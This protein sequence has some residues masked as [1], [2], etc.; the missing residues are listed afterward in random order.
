MSKKAIGFILLLPAV[1][2]SLAAM[3]AT[4]RTIMKVADV[5]ASEA[6]GY[7]RGYALGSI[8]GYAFLIVVSIYLWKWVIKL[9]RSK[10]KHD[11]LDEIGKS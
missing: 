7:T 5:F 10:P 1:F 11:A 4:P 8:V 9:T 2:F 3:A 6:S